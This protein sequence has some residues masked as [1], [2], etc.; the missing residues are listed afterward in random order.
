MSGNSSL[1]EG[2][3]V[4]VK[5]QTFNQLIFNIKLSFAVIEDYSEL[6]RNGT[7]ISELD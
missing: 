7:S 2:V 1:K 5:A 3:L 6:L 4:F